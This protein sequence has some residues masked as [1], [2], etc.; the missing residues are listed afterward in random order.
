MPY[1]QQ[2]ELEE[3]YQ[4]LLQRAQE[5]QR[6]FA[7]VAEQARELYGGHP[8]I[9]LSAR[10][11][12]SHNNLFKK[13]VKIIRG[14]AIQGEPSCR[15]V[16]RGE[17]SEDAATVASEKISSIFSS[18][19][20]YPQ[21][22]Q[23]STD[24]LLCSGGYAM[25]HEDRHVEYLNWFD[26]F[27]DNA[28]GC[29]AD[30]SKGR[31]LFIRRLVDAAEFWDTYE[32]R[33]KELGYKDEESLPRAT[34]VMGRRIV[35][36]NST[37]T[38]SG[39]FEKKTVSYITNV[40]GNPTYWEYSS[41][42]PDLD[43][44]VAEWECFVRDS[45]DDETGL[46]RWSRVLMFED[47]FLEDPED[48]PSVMPGPNVAYFPFDFLN[49]QVYQPSLY[50]DVIR[51]QA[52]YNWINSKTAQILA[53]LDNPAR[54][55]HKDDTQA[56]KKWWN[57]PGED[58][59]LDQP[60][61]FEMIDQPVPPPIYEEI[62]ASI[63]EDASENTGVTPATQGISPS[64]DSSGI[65]IEKLQRSAEV[66]FESFLTS[67]DEFFTDVCRWILYFEVLEN[68]QEY[69]GITPQAVMK[70]AVFSFKLVP[71]LGREEKMAQ[72]LS[73]ITAAT[74]MLVGTILETDP[75]ARIDLA[76]TLTGNTKEADELINKVKEYMKAAQDASKQ[77]LA[78]QQNIE[79]EMAD[80]DQERAIEEKFIDAEIES[81]KKE[82]DQEFQREQAAVQGQQKTAG[83]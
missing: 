46:P 50:V 76:G 22:A 41:T 37:H 64:E 8:E 82:Q 73:G 13:A 55:F 33:L 44:L 25:I 36:V 63:K 20:V 19:S 59:A 66:F 47:Y 3:K 35:G 61:L 79:S 72:T 56:V 16:P 74:N 48:L 78:E 83:R 53:N 18:Q 77:Q 40:F 70:D 80:E 58:L 51:N 5:Q 62:K 57:N 15:V 43:G 7:V 1:Q 24:T 14:K 60:T 42:Q 23:I 38:L 75:I 21:I 29:S 10:A 9:A 32:K 81:Q 65:A 34:K 28:L 27:P 67:R 26:V 45:V 17:I 69:N 11:P 68:P 39:V 12:S 31:Y 49:G 4:K 71:K 54:K 6:L 2:T 30:L 52:S